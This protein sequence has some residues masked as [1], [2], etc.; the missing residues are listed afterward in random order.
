M[1][2]TA[3]PTQTTENSQPEIQQQAGKLIGQFAGYVGFRTIKIGLDN[4]LL[5]T[6][7]DSPGGLTAEQLAKS[8][9]T[10]EFYTGVWARAAYGAE[11]IEIDGQNRYTLASHMENL[12]LN[13]DYPGYVGGITNVFSAPEIFDEFSASLKSGKRIWWNDTSPEFIDGVSGTGRPFYNRLIPGGLEK[14]PGLTEKL[15]NGGRVLELASGAGRGLVKFAKTYP[16][17]ELIGVDG[18]AHSVD[19]AWERVNDEGVADRVSLVQSTLED[20][21]EEEAYDLVFINI[22]MHE[23]RDIDRVTE[24]VKRSLKPGGVF[25]ISDFPFPATHEGLRTPPARLLTGIQYFE[26]Q[27]D[28]Q[29]VPTAVFVDLLDRH[30]FEGV[31]AFDITPVHN[32]IFGRK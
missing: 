31:T 17:T 16:N 21:V 13:E 7:A 29:L 11:L 14:V 2:T 18:D 24:N 28:D 3:R 5:Q 9:E 32:L 26:A 22:S 6:L 30:G 12:L 4:G 25:V 20:F 27:I 15:A 8:A 23:C 1:T 19:V 10:D